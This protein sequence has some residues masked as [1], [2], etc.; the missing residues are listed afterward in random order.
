MLLR[1]RLATVGL[2]LRCQQ[3]VGY[4]LEESPWVLDIA[5]GRDRATAST[6]PR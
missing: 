5:S 3:R 2:A 1:R 4:T 6:S